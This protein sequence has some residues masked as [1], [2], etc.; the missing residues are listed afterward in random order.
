MA[1]ALRVFEIA[2]ELGVNSKAIVGK[3]QAEGVPGITNHMS[4]VKL[5][6][7]ATIREWFGDEG[8]EGAVTAVETA[9]KVDLEKVRKP[10]RKK[11]NKKAKAAEPEPAAAVAEPVEPA[12]A[13][14]AVETPPAEAAPTV[15]ETPPEAP[16]E[17]EPV[18]E[19][20]APA[21]LSAPEPGPE[22]EAEPEPEPQGPSRP[23]GQP[24]VPARPEVIQPVGAKLEKPESA[25]LKGPRVIR[26][27]KADP[28][29]RAPA[30]R[31][32]G[33]TSS[34][35][36]TGEGAIMPPQNGG[37]SAGGAGGTRSR[38]GGKPKGGE[39]ESEQQRKR[40]YQSTRRGR[41]AEAIPLN[42]GQMSDQDL[43]ELDARLKGAPGYLK[44]RRRTM[45]GPGGAQ[46]Q[47][48]TPAEVGGH[49]EIEEPIT[50]K[51]LSAATGIKSVDIVK[52]LFAKG[53]MATINSAIDAEAAM[54]VCLE[55]DIEL[56]VKE[57]Q[58]AEQAIIEEYEARE[59]VDERRRPPVV[60]VLGHVDHGKTSLLDRIRQA[61]VAN[62]EDGGITQHVGAYRVTITGSDEKEKTVVFLDTPGHEAFTSMRARGASMTD[63]VVLLVAADDG[64]MPQTVE[65]INHAKAANTP[66]IVALNKIDM[67]QATEENIRRIYGQLAEHD[68]NPVE[69]GGETEVIKT[70]ATEGTGINDL[71]EVLD[72][73]AELL[74][75]KAD[76][77]GAARGMVIE[78]EMQLGRGAVG[79]VLVQDGTLKVGDFIVLGRAYGRV[80]EMT[81]DRGRSIKEALPATP[82]ELSGID[83]IPDAGDKFYSTDSLQ[84]AEDAAKQ[85]R[86]AERQKQ[87]ASQGKVSLDSIAEAMGAKETKELR[88]VIK[89]DVQGSV[90]VL[91]ETIGR[92]GND[93]VSV[94]VIHSAVG[95]ITESDVL[96]A[97]ASDAIIVGFHVVAPPPVRE[98]ADHR[99]IEIR[100]YRV[101]YDLVDDIRKGLEGMLA[102]ETKEDELGSAQVRQVFRIGKVGNIAGCLV[103]DGMIQKGAKAR[104]IRDGVVV[105]ENRDIQT[106]RRVKDDAREVRAGTECG[107]H[108]AGF[109]DVKP[110]DVIVCYKV[111]TVARTLA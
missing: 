13:P 100:I 40:R 102:P 71:L 89:A 68:L 104:V 48:L 103:T 47:A 24:N 31:P 39:R 32:S 9:E 80:R 62:H 10:A 12:D 46:Q 22:P 72:Y 11:A 106:L 63:L 73:Q 60:A 28:I 42:R 96:L 1:K 55:Y 108:I 29:P 67:P 53:I 14:P 58:T 6:L 109:D 5:G 49:V 30:R 56:E 70:S 86:E 90:D 35:P 97:D 92:Q 69:W 20:Q 65:S 2:K 38:A 37:E 4:T 15:V 88:V 87:L 95:G 45:K 21:E 19:A 50:I 34:G 36:R 18:A 110:D 64:V 59:A 25:T 75:L 107:I 54:E 101:I 98:I 51:T 78:S 44:K 93:E 43:I 3:C 85:F 111:E 74:D 8:G 33:P 77:G 23:A 16:A 81:D 41:S 79:R 82:V 26:V 83:Q 7:A 17:V 91:R 57:R 52:Y 94:K 105:T 84:R 66:I 27:E 61:D 99:G 76:F